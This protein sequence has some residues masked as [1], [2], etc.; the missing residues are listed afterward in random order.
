MTSEIKAH[1]VVPLSTGGHATIIIFSS[2]RPCR[3][4][5]TGLDS[6][7]EAT[8]NLAQ[9]IGVLD[10]TLPRIRAAALEGFTI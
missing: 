2:G 5:F 10:E 9:V 8:E 4:G 3:R 6:L 1:G 7:R